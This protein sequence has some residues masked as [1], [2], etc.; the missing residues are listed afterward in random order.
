[1]WIT[2]EQ[3][4]GGSGRPTGQGFASSAALRPFGCPAGRPERRGNCRPRG[5]GSGTLRR[6][7][8]Q[9]TNLPSPAFFAELLGLKGPWRVAGLSLDLAANELRVEVACAGSWF[10]CPKCG[11]RS[12][13]HDGRRRRWVHLNTME[14][15]TVVTAQLPR[16]R[17][18]EH[19]V[20]QVR[21][22]WAAP[23][24]RFTAKF[25]EEVISRLRDGSFS[26]VARQLRLSWD[27]VSGIQG[28]AVA[29]GLSRRRLKAP[30]E[31]GV[32]ETSFRRG[33]RYFTVVNDQQ[34][35]VLY[36]AEG[37]DTAALDGF[38]EELGDRASRIERVAMDMAKPYIRSVR[39]HTDAA[40]VFDKFHVAKHLGDAV[41]KVRRAEHRELLRMG[42]DRLVGTKYLWLQNEENMS[43]ARRAQ[44]SQL[45]NSALRVAR[46]R[47]IRD[48]AMGLWGYH[49]RGWAER[50]WKEWYGWA[51]R[52]RME[53]MKKVAT[54][55][56]NH[57]EGVINAATCSLT[58]APAESLNARI[59]WIKKMACGYRNKKRLRA[60]I[61]F[62]LGGLDM[63]PDLGPVHTKL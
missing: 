17:C 40:I 36:V 1:M 16:V 34:G 10:A 30:R 31:I 13:R 29:R 24:S 4:D 3:W 48:L 35:R 25:E 14:Y 39:E 2:G 28:R 15:R 38:F 57:W 61:Y 22:P 26:A 44:F 55:I 45:R 46:A 41:D 58:N 60:A 18:G 50:R 19:G 56:L 21:V 9:G 43:R 27:Q 63:S 20:R 49:R 52:C 7:E 6:M 5:G 11:A 37:R 47:A 59:Q 53:P 33:H 42:D 32:D 54:T 23:G 51:I 12:P 62:H 8:I